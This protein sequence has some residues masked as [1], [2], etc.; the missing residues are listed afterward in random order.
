MGDHGRQQ[1]TAA[2]VRAAR[3]LLGW[4][5]VEL[6]TRASVAVP[7]VTQFER[8]NRMP[9]RAVAAAI[10]S[11]LE[12]AGVEFIESG[13]ASPSGGGVGVRLIGPKLP[14]S[15]MPSDDSDD[16]GPVP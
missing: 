16:E 15:P 10:R 3:A 11:A 6:A 5:Q 9:T 7:T 8:G 1:L 14:F 4:S 2:Q 13:A 12:V